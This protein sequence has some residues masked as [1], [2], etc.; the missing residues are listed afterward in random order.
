MRK[1]LKASERRPDHHRAFVLYGYFGL[2]RDEGRLLTD[3]DVDFRRNEIRIRRETTKTA[4]GVRTI[5][6]HPAIAEHLRSDGGYVLGGEEPYSKEFFFTFL[7]R[8]DKVAGFHLRL[9]MFRATLDTY[10]SDILQ[11][12][13]PHRKAD[14][15]LKSIL[16]HKVK[17]TADMSD[18]YYGEHEE[19]EED[20][21][22]AMRKWHP[23]L[24]WGIIK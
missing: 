1:L 10:L 20:R 4:S 7:R 14:L 8:Y 17:G 16:G 3:K 23:F 22:R 21:R 11:R 18:Y 13:L 15:I 6:F 9:K 19:F 5:P 12:R 2:R 24:E